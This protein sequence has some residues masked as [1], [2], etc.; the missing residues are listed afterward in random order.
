LNAHRR[1]QK[2]LAVVG[3]QSG[4]ARN[5]TG[6]GVARHHVWITHTV[7]AD[8]AGLTGLVARCE[9]THF[10]VDSRAAEIQRLSGRQAEDRR[11]VRRLVVE[12]EFHTGVPDDARVW[13]RRD[14]VKLKRLGLFCRTT[15]HPDA[16]RFQPFGRVDRRTKAHDPQRS[17]EHGRQDGHGARRVSANERRV[18]ARGKTREP[19][20]ARQ[21]EHRDVF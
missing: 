9:E 2:Q 14:L 6:L 5:L 13:D 1:G 12:I 15:K 3:A 19:D 18:G 10:I 4:F 21:V 7:I 17:P 8:N 20:E 11:R 16:V